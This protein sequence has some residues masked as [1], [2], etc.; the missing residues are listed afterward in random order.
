MAFG[1]HLTKWTTSFS[2]MYIWF[3]EGPT[4]DNYA[5]R[6]WYKQWPLRYNWKI[7]YV[8][9]FRQFFL[10]DLATTSISQNLKV[11]MLK[12]NH[13]KLSLQ[14]SHLGCCSPRRFSRSKRSWAL[15]CSHDAY[16]MWS[17]FSAVNH[18]KLWKHPY[19]PLKFKVFK[20]SWH[21]LFFHVFLNL[22]WNGMYLW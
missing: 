8:H 10:H 16:K 9:K 5:H 15:I 18:L 1:G 12:I 11:F 14:V 20:N 3:F 17:F 2:G 19:F 22:L 13:L 7:A 6:T 4:L 21:Y